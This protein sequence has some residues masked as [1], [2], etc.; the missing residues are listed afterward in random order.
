MCEVIFY[1]QQKINFIS[2]YMFQKKCVLPLG[3]Y[4]EGPK[5][6]R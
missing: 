6:Q 3:I 2:A 1:F 5:M 4:G